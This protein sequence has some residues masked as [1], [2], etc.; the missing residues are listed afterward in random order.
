MDFPSPETLMKLA[1]EVVIVVLFLRYLMSR[2]ASQQNLEN[3]R[4]QV[5]QSMSNECHVHSEKITVAFVDAVK[6][7]R[8]AIIENTHALGRVHDKLQVQ[9]RR[10]PERKPEAS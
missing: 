6:E 3:Q 7:S 2:D 9:R 8:E 4:H 10:E 5:L 1:G